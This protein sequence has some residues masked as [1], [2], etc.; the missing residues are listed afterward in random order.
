VGVSRLVRRKKTAGISGFSRV[1]KYGY[2]CFHPCIIF[3]PLHE[4]EAFKGLRLPGDIVCSGS[5]F[6]ND[7]KNNTGDMVFF[8]IETKQEYWPTVDSIMK[9]NAYYE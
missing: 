8:G 7:Y 9:T 2:W 6:L 5:D 1:G 4:F 3:C